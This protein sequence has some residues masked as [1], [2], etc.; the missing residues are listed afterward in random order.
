[1]GWDELTKA[2]H[3]GTPVVGETADWL[4]NNDVRRSRLSKADVKACLDGLASKQDGMVV[5]EGQ[6]GGGAGMTCHQF[7]GGTF[8]CRTKRHPKNRDSAPALS[9]AMRCIATTP[10]SETYADPLLGLKVL[11]HPVESSVPE[12]A[13][14]G[15]THS[16]RYVSRTMVIWMI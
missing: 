12:K 8:G 3:Y 15:S 5:Q 11:E 13:A 9:V 4:I 2:R 14:K 1:M 10:A 6:H 16:Q 7:T